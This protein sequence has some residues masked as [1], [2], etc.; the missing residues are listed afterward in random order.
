MNSIPKR[1][2]ARSPPFCNT[3]RDV[4]DP[5]LGPL[6]PKLPLIRHT[7]G[8]PAISDQRSKRLREASYR[9]DT[10]FRESIACADRPLSTCLSGER[11][12]VHDAHGVHQDAVRGVR[13]DRVI[14]TR[15]PTTDHRT[16]TTAR[17]SRI[18]SGH[19]RSFSN[20]AMTQTRNSESPTGITTCRGQRTA[21]LDDGAA[22]NLL[23]ARIIRPGWDAS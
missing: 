20:G 19:P 22:L 7:R 16:P 10:G 23:Y 8:W 13:C 18:G 14:E 9:S 11:C 6:W 21:K 1:A 2:Q 4:Q 5:T 3:I 17:A 15:S 12:A